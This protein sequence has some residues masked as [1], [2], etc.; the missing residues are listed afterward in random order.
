MSSPAFQV[1]SNRDLVHY[2]SS[3]IKMIPCELHRSCKLL[4]QKNPL[5]C[6][7]HYRCKPIKWGGFKNGNS[8]AAAG[9]L[10]ALVQFQ[11][12]LKFSHYAMD[13]A[14]HYGHLEV[15]KWLHSNRTEG[16]SPYAMNWAAEEGHLEVVKWLHHNRTEGCSPYA[17]NWAS[18]KGHLEVVKWLHIN[19]TEGCANDAIYC[20]SKNGHFDVV[21]W[22][23]MNRTEGSESKLSKYTHLFL[24]I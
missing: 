22:L 1:L 13:E 5:Q 11:H 6:K 23:H 12:Q 4:S 20:A 9:W 7:Y 17:L 18:Q 19:R 3:F 16:C 10:F 8:V 2:I 21:K 15:V 14:A 24:Q